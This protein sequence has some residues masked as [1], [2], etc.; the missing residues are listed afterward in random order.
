M[1]Q[2]FKKLL[3]KLDINH[4]KFILKSFGEK[5]NEPKTEMINKILSKNLYGIENLLF[6]RL[7]KYEIQYL[8]E[9]I[10]LNTF[11]TKNELIDRILNF[12]SLGEQ[13][14]TEYDFWEFDSNGKINLITIDTSYIL[15]KYFSIDQLKEICKNFQLPLEGIK[16]TL[17]RRISESKVLSIN[18]ILENLDNN[19]IEDLAEELNIDDRIEYI[20]DLVQEISYKLNSRSK[21]PPMEKKVKNH[22][23]NYK[24]DIAISY[25]G[26]ENYI[27]EQI[28]NGLK[29]AKI[30]VFYDKYEVSNLWGRDLASHLQ[31][32]Y[33]KEAQFCIM[34]ISNNYKEKAWPNHERAA[35]IERYLNENRYYI[36]PILI[37]D[38]AWVSG[39]PKTISY[40]KWDETSVQ[41]I[42]VSV[43]KKLLENKENYA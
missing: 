9:K 27:A 12:L 2:N 15:D 42:V 17:I 26:E 3:E 19:E 24:Y 5:S 31:D 33:S 25:A 35:A 32:I 10:G 22:N 8:A 18:N 38:D 37:H 7:D 21:K 6:F 36:L 29:Q 20:D 43:K 30:N 40:L 39:I 1:N 41:E 23:Q 13:Y 28:A 16:A 4:L 11:G 34:L 14:L